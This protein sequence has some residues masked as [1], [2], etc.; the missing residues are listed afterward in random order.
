MLEKAH[1]SSFFDLN[2]YDPRF[3]IEHIPA[4]GF[5]YA[6]H[7]S[8]RTQE[9]ANIYERGRLKITRAQVWHSVNAYVYSK[10]IFKLSSVPPV[11]QHAQSIWIQPP[12]IKHHH[13][14]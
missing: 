4:L 5:P 3:D 9:M 6:L 11:R 7:S 2:A 8:P 13:W 10:V 14:P 12:S 1:V